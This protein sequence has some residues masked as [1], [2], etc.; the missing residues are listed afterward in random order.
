MF[1][2]KPPK[3][4]SLYLFIISSPVW[5]IVSTQASNGTKCVPSP[6]SDNEAAETALIAPSPLRSIQGTWT[7]PAT[8]SHGYK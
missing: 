6:L 2:A 3:D 1:T 4:V 5:R 8:G 7:K